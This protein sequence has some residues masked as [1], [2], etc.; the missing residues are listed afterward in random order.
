MDI[1]RIL[2]T[3]T[4]IAVLVTLFKICYMVVQIRYEEK[5]QG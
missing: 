3:I 5:R 2:G 4:I 1:I